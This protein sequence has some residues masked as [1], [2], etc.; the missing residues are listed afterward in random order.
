MTRWESSLDPASTEA[1]LKQSANKPQQVAPNVEPLTVNNLK[2]I[3]QRAG[4]L[5]PQT[6]LALA[7]ANASDA[8]ID[9]AGRLKAKQIVEIQGAPSSSFPSQMRSG[10][11][12]NVRRVSRW[13]T[14]ALNFVPEYA[15][16]AIA[17]LFDDND[18]I[19]GW[20]I[21]TTLGSMIENP[22]LRGEGFFAS[23]ELMK[24][25]AER[26]RRYRGVLNVTDSNPEG[27]AW[28]VGRASANLVFQVNSRPYNIMSGFLD[29]AVLIGT[30]PTGPITKAVKVANSGRYMVP[31]LTKTDIAAGRLALEAEAGVS[32]GLLGASANG[33]KLEKFLKTNSRA[34][35]LIA[36][37]RDEDSV[38]KIGED[39]FDGQ[40]SNDVVLR[41][42]AAKTDDEVREIIAEGWVMGGDTLGTDVRRY[43]AGKIKSG[44]GEIVEKIPL[45]DSVRK[46]RWFAKIPDNLL[47]LSG[48][49]EDNRKTVTN[50][51]RA[52]R[53]TNV[54]DE[55]VNDLAPKLYASFTE[56]ATAG[57]RKAALD[58]FNSVLKAQLVANGMP[59]TVAD[60]LIKG[61]QSGIDDIRAYMINR[62]G[63]STDNGM[64]R[65]LL[66]KNYDYLPEEEIEA[67][68]SHFGGSEGMTLA[69]PLQISELL[70]RVHVLPN[71]RELRRATA[72]PFFARVTKGFSLTAKRSKRE[73]TELPTENVA[74]LKELTDELAVLATETPMVAPGVNRRLL[75]QQK[76]ERV[77]QIDKERKAL[78]RTVTRKVNV[79]EQRAA[80]EVL[81][82]LQNS[83][84][85][86]LA[87]AT[88][89][90][91]VRNSLDAQIRLAFGG[92]S[93]AITHPW[94]Y[95]MLILGQ[96][97]RRDVI[98]REILGYEALDD[99]GRRL[100][101]GEKF[102]D[103][104][105]SSGAEFQEKLRKDLGFGIRQAGIDSPEAAGVLEKTNV[106][107]VHTR[108]SPNG[109]TLHTDGVAQTGGLIHSDPLQRIAAEGLASGQ[110]RG[111][112][113]SRIVAFIKSNDEAMRDVES[114]YSANPKGIPIV[115]LDGSGKT[116]YLKMPV[117]LRQMTADQKDVFLNQHA[118]R[119]VLQNVETQSGSM[120]DLQFM[121]AFNYVPKTVGTLTTE[122][123]ASLNQQAEELVDIINRTAAE[124]PTA[125]SVD[126][127][128]LEDA[129]V[130]YQ[131]ELAR[132]RGQLA[133]NNVRV[134][135]RII[136]VQELI[137]TDAIVT[138]TKNVRIGTVVRL[139]DEDLGVVTQLENMPDRVQFDGFTGE[140]IDI[141]G[142]ES[143]VVTPVHPE[144]A[145]ETAGR[146]TG[147]V[148][149]RS[150]IDQMPIY[151]ET[152][153]AG[154][155]QTVKR[156]ILDTKEVDGFLAHSREAM[157][158][159]TNLF[160]GSIYGSTTRILDR[161]PAFRQY[162]YETLLENADMLSP[163]QAQKALDDLAKRAKEQNM[164]IDEFLKDKDVVP[165]LKA[166]TLTDGTA[167]I[168]DLDEYARVTAIGKTKELLFD[169]S[170][171]NNLE[172]ALRI[173]MPFAPAWR[174]VLGTYAG[175]AK[176]NPIGTA[177]SFQ[178]VYSGAL[179]ADYDN[180][181]RGLF[182]KDPITNQ[183]MFT[184]PASGGLAKIFTGLDAGLE[185]PVKRLSQ[186]IQTYP[187]IGPYMQVLASQIP[188]SP[189]LDDVRSLLLPYGEKSIG[190][191]F[192]PTPQWISKFTQAIIA[193][194]G[195]LDNVFGNTYIETLR[196]LG[197]SGEYDLDDPNDVARIKA[198]AKRKARIL[199]LMRAAS[200]FIGPTSGSTEFKIPTKQGD[201]FVSSLVKEFYDL[202]AENYDSAVPKFLELY[203][204]EIE[205]YI[206]SKTRS[207]TQGLEATEEFGVWERQN[208]DLLDQYPNV[209]AYLA[210]EGSEFN[211][212]VWERQIRTGKR[213][214]LT[215]NE[216]IGLAQRRIGAAKYSQA[217]R[218]MGPYPTAIQRDI[219]T[220]YRTF[221]HKNY[222]GFPLYAEFTVGEFQNDVEQLRNL[223]SDNRVANNPTAQTISQYLTYRDQAIASYVGQGG[224][225]TGFQNAKSA[226]GLREAL[227][228]IGSVLASRDSNFA[229]VY[230]RLLAQEVEE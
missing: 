219:L 162:Y 192:N 17:Q 140:Y 174:E 113:V 131:N 76:A 195:K 148:E 105:E 36:R 212:S 61:A 184:F 57:D 124:I 63:Q 201:K 82:V 211:F 186:G 59:D 132:I 177:R 126:R 37:I 120:G 122:A 41:M 21:S 102:E 134:N 222:P 93:S 18:D 123:A 90:Y 199:T 226:L 221:L 176:G 62:A 97:K 182:Y 227:S 150:L 210:P 72:N 52:M 175:F 6:Q 139:G 112:I 89:G 5:E 67:M 164:G 193:D 84:W 83:L 125:N 153:K 215:D 116:G 35:A 197:A 172:D 7:R 71:A 145:F 73:F 167:T 121:Q 161:S 40:L 19:D 32:H 53:T 4:W 50:M 206:S 26:A 99:I 159:F 114:I 8:T 137:D 24:K 158:K 80:I 127:I 141:P 15:Q 224:K 12:D 143:V 216:I 207:L 130:R 154:L 156:E 77:L 146:R 9:A 48:T 58:A 115:A 203:G 81:D 133:S 45:V 194:T 2:R 119:I 96:S 225:P 44:L 54:S 27:S 30:D 209:A 144:K 55:V 180:D 220:R 31:L 60:E 228:S 205:L 79:G 135:P 10:I 34:K 128:E 117:P 217:R 65:H 160:F 38:L 78:Y 42:A 100:L 49:S 107:G 109:M 170:N 151:N 187:A 169:A 214:R 86:P 101:K 157:D 198:D 39:I 92:L 223:V 88:G 43:Q 188:D 200:Q 98:G 118:D 70:S 47:V 3:K 168:D 1:I 129:L 163:E 69:G 165:A 111:R 25:Q 106:W 166:S 85:K 178:R 94:E 202:Q 147:S 191:A 213:E 68:L 29:A 142:G 66:N 87:L 108:V 46:S 64:Y 103:V 208:G 11:M 204:D 152:N 190:S 14:A 13:G 229:R 218:M 22:E 183:L 171:R 179:G 20:F 74:K 110:T 23:P 181:G 155:P 136:T 33:V 185:A 91:I 28:T 189:K 16:G 196:A 51:I 173:I 56:A 230:E 75:S 138:E 104:V 95:M 149:A